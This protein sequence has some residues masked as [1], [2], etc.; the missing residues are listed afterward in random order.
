[1][2][3]GARRLVRE[4]RCAAI[5]IKTRLQVQQRLG[6]GAHVAYRGSW[7]A[8][9]SIVREEGVRGLFRGFGTNTLNLGVGQLYI[10]LYE[11][12]RAPGML[13]SSL[14]TEGRT[15]LA[16][17]T[18]VVVSQLVGNPIDVVAQRLMVQRSIKHLVGGAEAAAAVAQ[19]PLGV[20]RTVWA[21]DGLRGFYRGYGVSILQNAPSS[22]TWWTS[23]G[24]YRRTLL[25]WTQ[26]TRRDM[27]ARG[28]GSQ[29]QWLVRGCETL[30]GSLAGVTIAVLA[31]PL[32]VIRSRVQV[33]GRS[34][35][36][37]VSALARDEGPRA[38]LSGLSARIWMLAPNGAV[39]ISA[40]ELVKRLAR[41]D[42]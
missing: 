9:R 14:S 22:A 21:K 10:S 24:V 29:A 5:L 37:V 15:F 36:D 42:Q 19:G 8:L 26:P 31:N 17:A 41:R 3:R 20:M 18:S 13:H 23:Y 40:Y 1:V 12:L 33:E 16:A 38:L 7:D 39:I 25:R 35:R 11:V 27:R 28:E 4:V 34:I 2:A 30:S 6:S 32:D